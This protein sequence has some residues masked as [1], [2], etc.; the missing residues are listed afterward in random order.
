MKISIL[1]FS[2]LGLISFAHASVVVEFIEPLVG[3]HT[4]KGAGCERIQIKM[5]DSSVTIVSDGL[6]FTVNTNDDLNAKI[7]KRSLIIKHESTDNAWPNFTDWVQQKI[8]ITKDKEGNLEA[9][10]YR[11][12]W[13]KPFFSSSVV[14]KNCSK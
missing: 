4:L 2:L 13:G 11:R 7:S 9:I 3:T 6:Y 10:N 5:D 8:K 12:G 1:T 14:K